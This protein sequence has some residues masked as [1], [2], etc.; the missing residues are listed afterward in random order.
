MDFFQG[1]NGLKTRIPDLTLT[2][3]HSLVEYVCRVEGRAVEL[4]NR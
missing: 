2:R 1:V 4:Q 3:L